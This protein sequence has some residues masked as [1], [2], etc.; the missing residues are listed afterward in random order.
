[1]TRESSN[2]GDNGA[3]VMTKNGKLIGMKISSNIVTPIPADVTAGE[4]LVKVYPGSSHVNKFGYP[5]SGVE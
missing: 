5:K 4:P 3:L 1:M 2:S